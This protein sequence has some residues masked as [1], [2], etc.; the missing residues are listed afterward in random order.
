MGQC[1][2][3]EK[4]LIKDFEKCLK[5]DKTPYIEKSREE[6]LK[7]YIDSYHS[8]IKFLANASGKEYKMLG[9]NYIELEK[10]YTKLMDYVSKNFIGGQYLLPENYM[11]LKTHFLNWFFDSFV[12]FKDK[13]TMEEERIKLKETFCK[14]DKYNILGNKDIITLSVL[15]H[16]IKQMDKKRYSLKDAITILLT[17]INLLNKIKGMESD[18]YNSMKIFI[19]TKIEMKSENLLK[20]EFDIFEKLNFNLN[21]KL[22]QFQEFLGLFYSQDQHPKT[23]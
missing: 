18:Y 6:I 19:N 7:L 12:D 8:D 21:V 4:N 17:L 5:I 16:K 9:E 14:A 3:V 1:T 13:K 23:F 11:I 10:E 15:L 22:E 20:L 2:S